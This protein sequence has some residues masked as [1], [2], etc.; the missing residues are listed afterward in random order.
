MDWSNT[1]LG[2]VIA[3]AVLVV[4]LIRRNPRRSR[5]F[6]IRIDYEE[7]VN[8]GDKDGK[9]NQGGDESGAS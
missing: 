7:R 4:V 6:G 3:I 5:R 8:N 2:A 9:G 1:T